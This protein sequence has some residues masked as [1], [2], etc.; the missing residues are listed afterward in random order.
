MSDWTVKI[1]YKN[2]D[3]ETVVEKEYDFT[4][5]TAMLQLEL[6]KVISEVEDA[7]YEFS[8]GKQKDEWDEELMGKFKKIRSKLLDQ[9]NAIKRLP[10]TLHYQHHSP[11]EMT[12]GEFIAKMVQNLK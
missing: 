7:F 8:G 4:Q 3:L 5:Y 1:E 10:Q 11:M 2:K 12:S 9:A 6:M